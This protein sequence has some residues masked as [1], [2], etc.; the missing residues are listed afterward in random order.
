MQSV[1]PANPPSGNSGVGSWI[2]RRLRLR[3]RMPALVSGGAFLAFA[4]TAAL[5]FPT[6]RSPSPLTDVL[7]IAAY[8]AASR[9]EF[10]VGPGLALP[11]ELM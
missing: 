5:T 2:E 4:V 7:F 10:V 3:D 1:M 9:V 8:A 6:L 11:T